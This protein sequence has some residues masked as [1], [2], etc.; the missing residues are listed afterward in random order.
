MVQLKIGDITTICASLAEFCGVNYQ[1][2]NIA[3]INIS[4][5]PCTI[6]IYPETFSECIAN[7]LNPS[8]VLLEFQWVNSTSSTET[9]NCADSIKLKTLG[10]GY[11]DYEGK[12]SISYKITQEDLDYFNNNP[13]FGL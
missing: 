9:N 3:D 2:Y 4:L 7:P 1:V 12:T 10:S 13:N 6:N 11:T 5:P 8:G